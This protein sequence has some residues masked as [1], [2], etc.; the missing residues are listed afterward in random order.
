MQYSI[1]VDSSADLV[2]PDQLGLE[3]SSIGFG[4]AP[5]TI[6]AG[7]REWRDVITSDIAEMVDF[8]ASYHGKSGTAC[9]STGDW[10]TAFNNAREVFGVAITSHLS[11]SYNSA[12]VA[13]QQYEADNPGARVHIVDSLSTGP[14]M[15]LIAEKL[16]ELIMEG[17]PFE[18]IRDEIEAYRDSTELV[19]S[20]ESLNNLANNGRVNPAVAKIAGMLGIRVVGSAE[21][22]ELDP[23]N[24]VR[25]ERKALSTILKEITAKGYAGGK[26]RIAHVFNEEAALKLKGMIEEAFPA[27]Q[28]KMNATRGLDSF[29]AERGGLLIG[30]ETK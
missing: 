18:K 16:K 26:I 29:Y 23:R 22:G 19:F 17:L 14:Q 11:G 1:V 20:L 27:A 12:I 5:L 9:P 15:W 6:Q 3:N 7:D 21:N 4:V 30:F 2:T 24:K 28:V 8:L 25:G 13:K 10:I